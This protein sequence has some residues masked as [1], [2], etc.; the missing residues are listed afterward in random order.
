[1]RRLSCATRI[2]YLSELELIVFSCT[3]DTKIVIYSIK[4]I[5][6]QHLNIG[7][8]IKYVTIARFLDALASSEELFII[9]SLTHRFMISQ[10]TPSVLSLWLDHHSVWSSTTQSLIHSFIY[11]NIVEIVNFSANVINVVSGSK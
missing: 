4:K 3:C 10:T 1:M 6:C 9:H 7:V 5:K 8:A 11:S 2:I